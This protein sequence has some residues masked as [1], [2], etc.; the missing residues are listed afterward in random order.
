MIKRSIY[1][2]ILVL[3]FTACAERGHNIDFRVK[4]VI[5]ENKT[6]IKSK[7]L[8]KATP[9]VLD[10]KPESISLDETTKNNIAGTLVLII[11]II[12]LL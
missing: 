8:Q 1:F 3:L 4:E 9:L 11:G 2:I 6:S 12:I 10:I 7:N 5:V